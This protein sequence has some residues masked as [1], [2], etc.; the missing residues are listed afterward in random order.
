MGK[1]QNAQKYPKREKNILRLHRYIFILKSQNKDQSEGLP[2]YTR[3]I[4]CRNVIPG[5]T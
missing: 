1:T 2:S 5:T 3:G 4:T